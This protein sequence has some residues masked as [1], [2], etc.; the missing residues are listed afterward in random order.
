MKANELR[1][2]N[3][4][5]YHEQSVRVM[6]ITER[7]CDLGYFQDSIGFMRE[8]DRDDFPNPLP[9]TEEWLLKFGFEQFKYNDYHSRKWTLSEP[10]LMELRRNSDWFYIL[11]V[12]GQFQIRINGQYVRRIKYVHEFQNVCFAFTEYEPQINE[13]EITK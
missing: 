6:S 12:K 2:G 11:K 4:L 13:L 8:F 5:N 10:I 1:I 7:Y 3:Y 9:L